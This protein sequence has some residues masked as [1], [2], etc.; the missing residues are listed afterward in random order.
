MKTFF[1]AV[2]VASAA[3][4]ASAQQTISLGLIK[5]GPNVVVWGANNRPTEIFIGPALQ[6]TVQP[7]GNWSHD[8]ASRVNVGGWIS[9]VARVCD[10]S[11]SMPMTF[12]PPQWASNPS[13]GNALSDEYIRSNPQT[14]DLKKRVKD[15]EAKLK[16]YPG[17]RERKAELE[18][19]FKKV[20]KLG[21]TVPG[22]TCE[23]PSVVQGYRVWVGPYQYGG[24][25]YSASRWTITLY[26]VGSKEKGY[27]FSL[28]QMTQQAWE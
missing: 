14:A 6:G 24:G 12:W 26:I 19:W 23:N 27:R 10:S 28:N 13:L 11:K 25:Y 3:I 21:I 16:K 9:I 22:A 5:G 17:Q 2:I 20:E 4:G 1:A 18:T 15:I 7:G 8:F